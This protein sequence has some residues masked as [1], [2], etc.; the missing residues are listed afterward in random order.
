MTGSHERAMSAWR[1]M[2]RAKAQ[3]RK[4]AAKELRKFDIT[5]GQ[6]WIIRLV[7]DA[8]SDGIKLN[9]LSKRTFATSANITRLV[10]RLEEAG[11]VV[12]DNDPGDRR[13]L[14]AKLTPQ[15]QELFDRFVPAHRAWVTQLMSCLSA[16]E[17]VELTDLLTRL[18]DHAAELDG[19]D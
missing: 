16:D 12:R 2:W 8:G 19:C 15:G 7:G 11:H 14:L 1:S 13:V 18:A 5:G 9:E 10:D 17:Q 6:A 4:A 3:T